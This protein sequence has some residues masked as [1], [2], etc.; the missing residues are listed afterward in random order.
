ME[1]QSILLVEDSPSD[2]RL[3]QE[4]LQDAPYGRFKVFNASSL[5]KALDVLSHNKVDAVLL[6]LGLPDSQGLATFKSVY[7]QAPHLAIIMLTVLDDEELARTAVREG[8]QDYLTKDRLSKDQLTT[9]VLIR[10]VRY[11][12]ERK[13]AEKELTQ[14]AYE[15]ERQ[16]RMFD[17]MLSSLPDPI[18]LLDTH[19]RYLYVCPQCERVLGV[20]R[21][22][23]IGKTWQEARIS[24]VLMKQLHS[25]FNDVV[26]TGRTATA[27]IDIETPTGLKRYE[28]NLSAVFGAENNIEAV[29][30]SSHD[31]TERTKAEAI[32]KES[33]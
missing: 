18:Y 31:I 26:T 13:Q 22:A 2:A 11:A 6:D 5:S 15:N 32:I 12:I 7:E 16:A 24:S 33:A 10:T 3:I 17:A 19:E 1:N 27:D 25:H 21:E 23:L 4:L 28:Y 8:A 29:V 9:D 14:F 30:L 20:P